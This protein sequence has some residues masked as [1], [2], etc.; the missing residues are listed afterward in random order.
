MKTKCILPLFELT[1]RRTCDI[2]YR[3]LSKNL[4]FPRYKS[5][6]FGVGSRFHGDC[7][8]IE[9]DVQKWINFC[10]NLPIRIELLSHTFYHDFNFDLEVAENLQYHNVNSSIDAYFRIWP[11]LFKILY[12]PAMQEFIVPDV[13]SIL[14]DRMYLKMEDHL[15]YHKGIL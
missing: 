7:K 14:I 11:V 5:N 12:H 3:Q 8:D 1:L 13:K 6:L 9:K 2:L 15:V 10:L 4:I